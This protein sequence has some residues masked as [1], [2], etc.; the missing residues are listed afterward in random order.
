MNKGGR[1]SKEQ[2]DIKWRKPEKRRNYERN[3][4]MGRNKTYHIGRDD[5]RWNDICRPGGA[6]QL[7]EGL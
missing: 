7:A 5:D 3:N 1:G 2:D 6:G 4:E